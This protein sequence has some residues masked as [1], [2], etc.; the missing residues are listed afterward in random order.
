MKRTNE[1]SITLEN[2]GWG[3]EGAEDFVAAISAAGYAEAKQDAVDALDE[4]AKRMMQKADVE[5]LHGNTEHM[6]YFL[7]A[8]GI[9]ADDV[10]AIRA[11]ALA[12]APATTK[13]TK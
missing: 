6:T 13:E 9:V 10:E 3:R 12:L 1:W 8:H 5:R 7:S 4:R 2:E 11:L